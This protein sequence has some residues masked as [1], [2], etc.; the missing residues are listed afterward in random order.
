MP[1]NAQPAGVV[2]LISEIDT[3]MK[4]VHTNSLDLSFGQNVMNNLIPKS[5]CYVERSYPE[6]IVLL[7]KNSRCPN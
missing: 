4:E 1:K 2:E 5:D 3:Q 7:R 6:E